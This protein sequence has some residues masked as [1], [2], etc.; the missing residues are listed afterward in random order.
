[1]WKNGK[2]CCGTST[3]VWLASPGTA[4]AWTTATGS[5]YLKYIVTIKNLM[6]VVKKVNIPAFASSMRAQLG[7]GDYSSLAVL[8]HCVNWFPHY[9]GQDSLWR[10]IQQDKWF[11]GP[12]WP[13]VDDFHLSQK[14]HFPSL[15]QAKLRTVKCRSQKKGWTLP[16]HRGWGALWSLQGLWGHWGLR[17]RGLIVSGFLL[18]LHT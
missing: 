17:W 11:A 1:M 7:T 14:P 12:Y 18:A 6:S 9:R 10:R 5:S 15:I 4:A 16:V 13:I 3:T 8:L 2:F